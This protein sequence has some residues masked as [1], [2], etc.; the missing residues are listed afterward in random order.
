MGAIGAQ[1]T[2]EILNT[3][4]CL[5]EE[6]LNARP[7]TPVSDD[8]NSLEV[9]TP[10]HFLSGQH[11]LTFLFLVLGENCSHSKRYAVRSGTQTQF[12]SDGC[13]ITS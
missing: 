1:L 8:L 10:K 4:M 11:S 2:D 12:G 9:L 5:V 7:L 6:S 13:V 3:T